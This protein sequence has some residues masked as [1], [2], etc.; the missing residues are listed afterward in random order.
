VP[1]GTF[2]P[3]D[4]DALHRYGGAVRAATAVI[5]TPITTL[6]MGLD[7]I[8]YSIDTNGRYDAKTQMAVQMF[9]VHFFSGSN[10]RPTAPNGLTDRQTAEEILAIWPRVS[11]VYGKTP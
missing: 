10:R 7:A 4:D 3:N 11:I 2:Q 1:G 8:G 9:Q 5:G 6:Q